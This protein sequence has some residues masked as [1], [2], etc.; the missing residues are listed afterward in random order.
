MIVI[1]VIDFLSYIDFVPRVLKG[2]GVLIV[3][4]IWTTS[5]QR[6]TNDD[7]DSNWL[8]NVIEINDVFKTTWHEKKKHIRFFISFMII[9]V[10]IHL[11]MFAFVNFIIVDCY[12]LILRNLSRKMKKITELKKLTMHGQCCR[13]SNHVVNISM[14]FNLKNL[15]DDC[16][17]KPFI[18][19][20]VIEMKKVR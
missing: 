13:V 14:T 4:M 9:H 1:I 12:A 15:I 3:H 2:F 7:V 6:R 10:V 5:L 11:K 20:R 17:T 8:M 18:E 16:L 19:I